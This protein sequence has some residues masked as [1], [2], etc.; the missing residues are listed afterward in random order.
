MREGFSLHGCLAE[1]GGCNVLVTHCYSYVTVGY[2]RYVAHCRY[3]YVLSAPA[4]L[5]SSVWEH[6]VVDSGS[7]PLGLLPSP[8]GERHREGRA[9]L[10]PAERSPVGSISHGSGGDRYRSAKKLCC[11]TRNSVT[12]QIVIE[13]RSGISHRTLEAT[14]W[15]HGRASPMA[16][17][18]TPHG[19]SLW[20]LS[21]TAA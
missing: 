20:R 16:A 3:R 4:Y 21:G 11:A 15:A 14:I 1:K 6:L 17:R 12:R 18:S 9:P 13:S 7:R 19:E 10:R 2:V 5:I 8:G